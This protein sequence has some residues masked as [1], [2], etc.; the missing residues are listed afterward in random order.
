MDEPQWDNVEVEVLKEGTGVYSAVA[1][2]C[3]SSQQT[4]AKL[5]MPELGIEFG[6]EQQRTEQLEKHPDM[7]MEGHAQ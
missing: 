4:L 5:Q 3:L 2:E 1:A 7:A 6:L